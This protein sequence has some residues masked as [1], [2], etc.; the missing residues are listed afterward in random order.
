MTLA[1]NNNP[2]LRGVK[3]VDFTAKKPENIETTGTTAMSNPI[4]KPTLSTEQADT[5]FKKHS[6]AMMAYG[7]AQISMQNSGAGKGM[8]GTE[9]TGTAG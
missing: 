3:P 5:Q 2:F 1:I 4:Q 9:T 7:L 8:I 6:Q